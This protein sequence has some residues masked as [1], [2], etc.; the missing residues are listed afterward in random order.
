MEGYAMKKTLLA[1]LLIAQTAF[2]GTGRIRDA[3][4]ADTANIS[5]SK[6]AGGGSGFEVP[7][8]FTA[9]LTRTVNT[10]S[11][12]VATGS[13]AGCL[14]AADFVT[15]NA[16]Q[17]QD[18]DL[19]AI[20]A[21]SGT[22]IAARTAAGTWAVRTLQAPA[23]G[24]TISN[25][26][27]VAGDPTFVLAN[28]LAALE[29]L[30]GTGLPAR[31]GTDAYAL[32]TL[33]PPAAGITITNPAGV[34]GDPTLVLA[35]DLA[36]LEG[37]SSTGFGARTGS[38]AWAQRTF[39]ATSPLNITNGAGIAG[40]PVMSCDVASASQ[41]GCL[42]STDWS[43]FNGK[44]ASGNY[45]TS[46]TT[47][48]V[49]SG[50]GAAAA[51]IQPGVVT[52]AK[53]AD[54]AQTTISGRALGAGTGVPTDLTA[55]Q[56]SAIIAS[57]DLA[58]TKALSLAQTTDTS[59]GNIDSLTTANI[60]SIRL[61]GAAPA[62]RGIAGGA[63]GKVLLIM[64]VSGTTVSVKNQDANPTAT[65]RIITGTAADV[66]MAD[67]A[68]LL[69]QY[70]NTTTRWRVI[71]GS[72]GGSSSPLT[73]KGDIHTFSTVD[74]RLAVGANDSM[75]VP[76]SA[77]ATGLKYV[78][79]LPTALEPAHT[80]DVTNSAGALAMTIAA[81]A[82]TNAKAAQM[83]NGTTKC[84]TTAGTGNAE[85]CTGAQ[86]TALLSAF[87]GDSG[88]GGT[89]G[90]VPAPATADA[91]KRKVVGAGGS[92]VSQFSQVNNLAVLDTSANSWAL[93]KPDNYDFEASIGDWLAYADA[94][95]TTPVDMTGGSPNTTCARNTSS[96]I[97]GTAD[98]LISITTG[99]SRQ[100]E[101]CAVV[102]NIP[103]AWR[104]KALRVSFPYATSGTVAAG[105]YVP[106]AYDV[107]N[108]SLLAPSTTVSGITSAA[109]TLYSLFQTQTS[110]AQ[111]RIGLHIARTSTAVATINLDDF[112]VEPD[113]N[114]AN[115]PMSDWIDETSAFT[116]TNFGTVSAHKVW[117]RRVGD[118]LQVRGEFLAGSTSAAE[119]AIT[120]PSKYVIDMTKMSANASTGQVGTAL[121][122][123]GSSTN[124]AGS[125]TGPIPVFS[126][127][128]NTGKLFFAFQT[129]SSL[130]AKTNA[131]SWSSGQGV[132]YNF[133]IPI[134]GWS[135]GGGTSPI[136][137]LS[138]W[139]S[140]TLTPGGTTSAPT[141]GTN[142][143]DAARWRRVGDSM[144]LRWDY[145]Q[146]G[147]GSAGSGKY[148][149]PIP[150]GYTIDTS[151]VFSDSA[152]GYT[153]KAGVGVICV[154]SGGSTSSRCGP[155]NVFDTTN[156]AGNLSEGT[157]NMSRW[158]SDDAPMSNA[159]TIVSF[160]AKVP[161]SGWTSTSS[162]TLTAPRS[163]IYLDT[164]AGYGATNTKVPYFTNSSTTGAAM[165]LTTND[166]TSGARI[167]VN[168]AGVY[169]MS[170][171]IDGATSAGAEAAIAK[172]ATG[173][174]TTSASSLTTTVRRSFASTAALVSTDATA[175]TAY[176][177]P[178]VV[179]DIMNP[180]TAGGVPNTS[181]KAHFTI[182]KVSN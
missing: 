180:Q 102:V 29:G 54:M 37:L 57:V 59:T 18:A 172:N 94:A 98:A 126:D 63:D 3:D 175:S 145:V 159:T 161:I 5:L 120:L 10:I 152:T 158:G 178:L 15:F 81:N 171:S 135:S 173:V 48:V 27:G 169:C 92:F 60:G 38:D 150:S 87:V 42:S 109:G 8:T 14:S 111:L 151:K 30:S 115:V 13:V 123:L 164:Y 124:F 84:R 97:D 114:Q 174:Y 49:A 70:D 177:E 65:N 66:T 108:S 19:D 163:T 22:G 25:P 165:T 69:L 43:T 106:Y 58:L 89:K 157:D 127:N 128:S 52:N 41:P 56:A 160:F 134:S 26:A 100:G 104:G 146:T 35:N 156:L 129:S 64:N 12:V 155:V 21:L 170:F 93:T 130:L 148:K 131:D 86:E 23:A 62:L 136:L 91:A 96:P 11:C 77:Q 117:T 32:R 166:A 181:A 179:G 95:A 4:I 39:S 61:T 139:T 83:A 110:T 149:L 79:T 107:T 50:A 36:A 101:G 147:A 133:S 112:K 40:N 33:Q 1:L 74:A 103:T 113:L 80:G 6:L 2:A 90:L 154:D 122:T 144:E 82:V 55:A 72:G 31:T 9:P 167:T 182:T 125:S 137:S 162:G 16:K 28:D 140:Y 143:T 99:A 53:R 78:T 51:T 132:I 119:A 24:I 7:L 34:A 44:Q 138:D 141:K 71:G 75:L 153:M 20:A 47:D 176:C 85:D 118:T 142:T 76:D 67:G 46:L 105:D 68:S 121:R 17:T 88:S 168:E 45:I 116:Y 73:T